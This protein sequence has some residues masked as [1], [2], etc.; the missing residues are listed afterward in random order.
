[1]NRLKIVLITT[2]LDTSILYAQQTQLKRITV[3]SDVH[4]MAPSLLRHKG[5]A[6][7]SYIANDRKMLVEST[8]LL[9]SVS[10]SLA[11]CQP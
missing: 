4:L 9:D 2:V 11:N 3:V 5:S 7:D 1:M 6:F 8:E 10:N